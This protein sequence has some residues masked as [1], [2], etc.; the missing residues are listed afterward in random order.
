[1]MTAEEPSPPAAAEA[2]AVGESAAAG[3]VW[4]TLQ[5]WAIRIAGLAT[6]AVLT[7]FLS[8]AD[9]GVVAA[10]ASLLPFFY[11]LSDLGFATYIVQVPHADR[12]VLS[13]AFWFSLT[14][15]SVLAAALWVGAP[16]LA[17]LFAAPG[18]APVLQA[19]SVLVILT[20]ISSVP[21]AL[22]RRR[23]QFR[24]LAVQGM[25]GSLIGQIVA[26]LAAVSGFGVWA[27][28]GQSLA[29][30]L[31]AT[32]LA[33]LAARWMPSW[34]FS[35]REFLRMTTFGGKVLGVEL[36]AMVRTT[37]EAAIV[38][39][40]L[41]TAA[42]GHLAI[43]QRL[44][45]IVQEL[46]GSALTPVTTVAFAKVKQSPERVRHAYTR[47]LRAT[48]AIVTPPLLLVAV[49]ASA[50][51]PLV[52]GPGWEESVVP[53]QLLALAGTVVAGASLD[54][55]LFYGLGRPGTW[56]A[57]G[58]A[59]DVVTIA[60]TAVLVRAGLVAVTV[61]FLAVAVVASAVRLVLVAR[62][63]DARAASLLRPAA[64]LVTTVCVSG[65]IGLLVMSLTTPWWDIARILV[66]GIAILLVHLLVT[67][68]LAREVFGDL[69]GYARRLA[70]RG[71]TRPSSGREDRH[72]VSEGRI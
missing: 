18:V 7:R 21:I 25:V 61:G 45:Q 47:S 15:G 29:A 5:K 41:G 52:F 72:T 30:Q 39:S 67:R 16:F 34:R 49:A 27:L 58:F 23:M 57:Y 53:A 33:C 60:T 2:G 44:V 20:A 11:L 68:V 10:A 14:V 43:S 71:F 4:L 24:A 59:V 38:T 46:T 37:G 3:V 1:M 31:V 51:I 65:G 28:V 35:R 66:V 54:H 55:G 42:F 64:Y 26:V 69:G 6:I 22:L 70:R 13:T 63:V 12:R 17:M 48:Y 19:L 32:V 40:S 9:F 50:I 62:L 56:F 8:P 36:V